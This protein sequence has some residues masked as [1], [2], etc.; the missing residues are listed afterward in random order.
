M[1][2]APDKLISVAGHMIP[3]PVRPPE[4]CSGGTP[5]FRGVAWLK[6][7]AHV[8]KNLCNLG[9]IFFRFSQFLGGQEAYIFAGLFREP[10]TG[11]Q[12]SCVLD[13]QKMSEDSQ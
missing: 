2:F 10:Q 3:E 7:R 8:L 6:C 12:I 11:Q 1:D 13:N 4:K 9:W 5:Y